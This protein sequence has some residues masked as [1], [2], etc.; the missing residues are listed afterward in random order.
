MADGFKPI[1]AEDD[2]RQPPAEAPVLSLKQRLAAIRDECAG[3]HKDAIQKE[4]DGKR[5]TE[6]GHIV[7]VIL[8]E[9]RPLLSAYGVVMIP[10]LVERSYTGNRCDVIVDFVFE[11]T[12]DSDE[13]RVVRWAGA[14]TDNG[15]KAFAKAGTNALKEMLKKVFLVTDRDDA[16]EETETIEHKTDEGLSRAQ[17]EKTVEQRRQ[18]QELWA[19][20]LK[21]GLENAKTRKDVE[22]LERDNK[23]ELVSE[24]LP[25]VTRMFFAELIA[26]RKEELP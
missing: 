15:G 18:T 22:R 8:S 14:D 19:K 17:V 3:I 24:N 6:K 12:D 4:K 5:W 20:A 23:D 25:S 13:S 2:P 21:A 26:K 11:R 10:N 9:F 16:K 7:E 1:A